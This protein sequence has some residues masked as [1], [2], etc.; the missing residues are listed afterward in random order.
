[1]RLLT[2]DG[3]SHWNAYATIPAGHLPADQCGCVPPD[4]QWAET[5]RHD[6]ETE[7]SRPV[8]QDRIRVLKRYPV[9]QERQCKT[10]PEEDGLQCYDGRRYSLPVEVGPGL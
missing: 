7:R 2:T 5:I 1:M 9:K 3:E 8:Q 6:P 10:Q 4:G